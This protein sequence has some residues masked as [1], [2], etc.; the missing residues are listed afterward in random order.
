[1]RLFRGPPKQ[2]LNSLIWLSVLP[3]TA[4]FPTYAASKFTLLTFIL[5][6]LLAAEVDGVFTEGAVAGA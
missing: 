4:L 1:M 3:I 5:P 2:L 6:L